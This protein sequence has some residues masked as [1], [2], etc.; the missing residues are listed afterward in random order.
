MKIILRL[1]RQHDLDLIAL[2]KNPK[3]CLTKAMKVALGAYVRNE[4]IKIEPPEAA[5]FQFETIPKIVT[6]FLVLNDNKDKD[7]IKWIENVRPGYRNSAVKNIVRNYLLSI[8]IYIYSK[9]EKASEK[10]PSTEEAI[11]VKTKKGTRKKKKETDL[12]QEVMQD[13]KIQEMRNIENVGEE[14]P[15]TLEDVL[16]PAE[17]TDSEDMFDIFDDMLNSF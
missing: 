13:K 4:N 14:T 11:L 15:I 10:P 9:E 1:Y 3:F 17:K 7:L 16:N 2:H 8:P 5:D 12:F 6:L